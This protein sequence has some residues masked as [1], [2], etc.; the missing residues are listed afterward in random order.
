MRHSLLT[1]VSYERDRTLTAD[2]KTFFDPE[3]LLAPSF[4]ASADPTSARLCFLVDFGCGFLTFSTT[5]SAS[6]TSDLRFL[7]LTLGFDSL[8][9]GISS[10]ESFSTAYFIIRA[11][12]RHV[13]TE[14]LVEDTTNQ[15][16]IRRVLHGILVVL[17]VQRSSVQSKSLLHLLADHARCQSS[18]N[19]PV[20]SA[21]RM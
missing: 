19:R 15:G 17:R 7:P 10:S 11:R 13:M 2:L 16:S 6:T 9:I 8:W 20:T 4:L 18:A 1:S 21:R 12:V 3:S 14:L 5:V